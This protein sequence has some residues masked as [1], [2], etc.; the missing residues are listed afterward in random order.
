MV[1]TACVYCGW[2]VSADIGACLNLVL[3]LLPMHGSRACGLPK[4]DREEL[5]W[6]RETPCQA[7]R[8]SLVLPR[9][10]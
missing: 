6:S 4:D 1:S 3:P 10:C 9:I 7:S 2:S 5:A 8:Q